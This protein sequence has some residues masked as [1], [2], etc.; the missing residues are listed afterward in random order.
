MV[1]LI[2]LFL[3]VLKFPLLSTSSS[4]IAALDVA[5]GHFGHLEVITAAELTYPFARE[6]ARIAD[7]TVRGHKVKLS[8]PATPTDQALA[9]TQMDPVYDFNFATEVRSSSDF[10]L[11][12]FSSTADN[13]HFQYND[14]TMPMFDLS[15]LEVLWP[16][17]IPSEGDMIYFQS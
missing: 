6:V 11:H 9:D 7:K 14:P 12:T 16:E 17:G 4:D 10:N 8:I 5:V 1:A 3:Y 2:N 13:I 15:D